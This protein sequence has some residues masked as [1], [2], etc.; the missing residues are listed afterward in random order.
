MVRLPTKT[1]FSGP[2]VP[3]AC[4]SEMLADAPRAAPYTEFAL[5][6]GVVGVLVIRISLKLPA[7]P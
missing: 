1:D 3:W 6:T 7:S 4:V 2:A 5:N